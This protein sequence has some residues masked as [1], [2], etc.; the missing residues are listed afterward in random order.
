MSG[1]EPPHRLKS[2]ELFLPVGV[3][4]KATFIFLGKLTP[5]WESQHR[6]RTPD[7]GNISII[8]FPNLIVYNYNQAT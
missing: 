5:D 2:S 6:G 4:T 8:G 3:V 7:G 1:V